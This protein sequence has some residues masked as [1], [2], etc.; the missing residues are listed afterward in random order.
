MKKKEYIHV[1]YLSFVVFN[2]SSRFA[3]RTTL[4]TSY[5]SNLNVYGIVF[6]RYATFS[7][8]FGYTGGTGKFWSGGIDFISAI[9]S[10]T[11]SRYTMYLAQDGS[12]IDLRTANDYDCMSV[13]A[14]SNLGQSSTKLL[15]SKTTEWEEPTT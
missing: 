4:Q 10:I 9:D 1:S 11:K 8:Y 13:I 7:F 2:S 12:Y 6:A 14:T 15:L 5:N 3:T